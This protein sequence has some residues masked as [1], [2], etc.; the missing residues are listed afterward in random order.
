M[1]PK[2]PN[3]VFVLADDGG[4]G[5]LACHGNEYIQTPLKQG[6]YGF[7]LGQPGPDLIPL[8]RIKQALCAHPLRPAHPRLTA[9]P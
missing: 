9:P 3:V 7:H 4:Y 2:Q 5:D 6:T 8:P 1:N